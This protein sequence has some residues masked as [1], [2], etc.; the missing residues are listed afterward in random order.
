VRTQ[1]AAAG[2]R[3]ERFVCRT[4]LLQIEARLKAFASGAL[5]PAHL[6]ASGTERA[7]LLLAHAALYRT[8]GILHGS[9]VRDWVIRGAT[10]EDVDVRIPAPMAVS[11]SPQ[12]V[13]DTLCC[14]VAPHGL[15]LQEERCKGP[16]LRLTFVTGRGEKVNVDI[17]S[18]KPAVPPPHCDTD[19]GSLCISYP[20]RLQAATTVAAEALPLHECVQRCLQRRFVLLYDPVTQADLCYARLRR[21]LDRGWTCVSPLPDSLRAKLPPQHQPRLAPQEEYA[22]RWWDPALQRPAAF[23]AQVVL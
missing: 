12:N 7:M 20:P 21:W 2:Y 19:V 14:A 3:C 11:M 17:S 9:F 15:R 18:P 1:L 5:P 22:V 8:E 4:P 23:S 16:T 10:A 13:R 6:T